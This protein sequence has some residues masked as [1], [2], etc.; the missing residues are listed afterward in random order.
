M[1]VMPML[2]ALVAVAVI[3]PGA[4]ASSVFFQNTDCDTTYCHNRCLAFATDDLGAP[5]AWL[6]GGLLGGDYDYYRV[7]GRTRD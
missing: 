7:S 4:R 2:A 5:E 6:Q 1:R 3:V